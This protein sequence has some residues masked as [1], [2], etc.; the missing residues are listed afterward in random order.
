MN[1]PLSPVSTPG[2][3]AAGFR[4]AMS[5]VAGAVHLVTTEGRAGKAGLTA[6][7]LAPVSD[8]PPML[9]VC[10][11]RA[12]RTAALAKA[13][14]VF[15]VSTLGAGHRALADIFAGRTDEHGEM[16]FDHG[17]WVKGAEGQPLL[18]DALASFVVRIVGIEPVAT[19]FVVIGEVVAV[20]RGQ[21]HA[22]L[23]YVRRGFHAV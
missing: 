21:A 19:H 17:S 9:L 15:A 6:T 20:E 8:D 4:E 14:G 10:L 18:A 22:G 11:N 5:R 23:V 7:A 12:S 13:N 16:R 3:D 2:V 1:N